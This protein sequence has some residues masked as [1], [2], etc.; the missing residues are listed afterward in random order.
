MSS[1]QLQ[2]LS[3][4]ILIKTNHFNLK[5]PITFN[6]YFH[7]TLK[8]NTKTNTVDTFFQWKYVFF[9]SSFF[10]CSLFIFPFDFD[11]LMLKVEDYYC[12]RMILLVL[13][14]FFWPF[15]AFVVEN[16]LVF[17]DESLEICQEN[18]QQVKGSTYFGNILIRKEY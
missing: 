9:S 16:Q 6:L 10:L 11:V 2:I 15:F 4:Q 18:K 12:H 5:F 3:H 13:L 1:N 8:L 17:G 14:D 7:L